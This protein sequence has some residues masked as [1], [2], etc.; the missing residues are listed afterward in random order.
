MANEDDETVVLM[1]KE[2]LLLETDEPPV[3]R[4]L[5]V[6]CHNELVRALGYAEEHHWPLK[7]WQRAIAHFADIG[8]DEFRK[9]E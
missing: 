8:F 5:D 6:M 1:T 7:W 3:K 4:Y 2:R 9:Q